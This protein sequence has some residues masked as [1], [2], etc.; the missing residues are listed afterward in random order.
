[1][2]RFVTSTCALFFFFVA[3]AALAVDNLDIA[4]SKIKAGIHHVLKEIDQT[5]SHTAKETGKLGFGHETEIRKLLQIGH[6]GKPYVVD[7][8]F[9]DHKG[10]MKIIEPER[11]RTHEGADISKQEANRQMRKTK[12]PRMGNVFDS[13]EGIKS[14]DFEYPVFSK[15]KQFIGSVSILIKQE[16]LIRNIAEVNEKE[17]GVQCWVM[18]KDGLILYETDPTQMGL[19]LFRDPLYKDYPELIALGKR[20]VNQKDGKGFYTFLIHGTKTIVKKRAVWKT[21]HFY[22]NDWIVVAYNA[23]ES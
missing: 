4:A 19:N 6:A 15:R 14:I 1:M 22:N 11:Y 7:I 21:L 18:Q 12:Q 3:S 8:A 23:V 20:M 17:L 13:V 5:V 16:E 10:I 2:R 9:I